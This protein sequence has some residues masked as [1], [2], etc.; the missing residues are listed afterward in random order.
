MRIN[1][2]PIRELIIPII[3]I[4]FQIANT[5]CTNFLKKD[6]HRRYAVSALPLGLKS[7]LLAKKYDAQTLQTIYLAPVNHIVTQRKNHIVMNQ[8]E[9]TIRSY[10]K[11]E[12]ALYYFPDATPHVALN[13]LNAWIRRCPPLVEA[14]AS[15]YQ[16]RH[17]K[18]FSPKAVRLIVEY[19]GEP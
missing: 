9:F 16:S 8:K 10:P 15:V 11:S 13:R 3:P 12:L 6:R 18:Y 1:I 7:A 19:L 4:R 17:A 2:I 14:L 5:N